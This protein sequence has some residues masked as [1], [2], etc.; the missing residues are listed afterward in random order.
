M[1]IIIDTCSANVISSNSCEI[2]RI[3]LDWIKKRGRVV[4]GGELHTEL[5]KTPLRPLILSWSSA[6]RFALIDQNKIDHEVGQFDLKLLKSNDSHVVALARAS[7]SS[8]IIT[9]DD[10]LITDIKNPTVSKRK[11]KAIKF[12]GNYSPRA[13]VVRGVLNGIQCR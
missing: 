8:A 6:G 2:S 7:D 10:L 4:S 9:G 12:S 13:R 11:R 3:I 5:M 1:C